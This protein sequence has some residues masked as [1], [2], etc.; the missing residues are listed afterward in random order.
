MSTFGSSVTFFLAVVIFPVSA[1]TDDTSDNCRDN[2]Y[3]KNVNRYA[4][5]VV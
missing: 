4:H 2:R 3:K 1:A 5:I